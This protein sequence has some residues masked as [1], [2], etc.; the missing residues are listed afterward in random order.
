MSSFAKR[1]SIAKGLE[2]T[3]S[4]CWQD[5]DVP[6]GE[7]GHEIELGTIADLLSILGAALDGNAW[8]V[9]IIQNDAEEEVEAA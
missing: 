2:P 1:E 3:F 8:D 7:S 4:V 5:D 6:P 9:S